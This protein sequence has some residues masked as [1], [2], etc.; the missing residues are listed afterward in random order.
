MNNQENKVNFS[1]MTGIEDLKKNA[2]ESNIA[3]IEDLSKFV[4]EKI[5]NNQK[6]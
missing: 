1:K 6:E 2:V 5:V 4:D 3:S